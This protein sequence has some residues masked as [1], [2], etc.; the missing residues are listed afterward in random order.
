MPLVKQVRYS[1]Q[2]GRVL[3]DVG[4]LNDGDIISVSDDFAAVLVNAFPDT[5][6]VVE[7]IPA[8]DAPVEDAPAKPAKK[9]T[10]KSDDDSA[11]TPA[12]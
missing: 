10:V 9:S 3:V 4:A 8:E 5:Y 11:D 12:S 6:M 7:D 2:N 1:G